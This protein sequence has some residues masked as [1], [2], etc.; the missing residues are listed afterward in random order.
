MNIQKGPGGNGVFTSV[1]ITTGDLRLHGEK[2]QNFVVQIRNEGGTLQHRVISG[3]NNLPLSQYADKINGASETLTA[4]PLV[5]ATTNFVAGFGIVAATP[6]VVSFDVLDQAGSSIF[7]LAMVEQYDGGV[8]HPVAI[9][10]FVFRDVNGLSRNRLELRFV[11]QSDAANFSIN[12]T[13]IPTG[14]N[15]YVRVLA[16]LK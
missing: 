4:T 16:F 7:F 1:D 3:T 15:L 6:H 8:S 2:L 10:A 12:T 11:K 5:D 14:S 9:P 13:N